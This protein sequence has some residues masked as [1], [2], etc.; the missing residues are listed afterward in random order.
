MG[1]D[2]LDTTYD[3]PEASAEVTPVDLRAGRVPTGGQMLSQLS[4]HLGFDR[5]A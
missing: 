4:C 3:R 5:R 1:L 2:Y